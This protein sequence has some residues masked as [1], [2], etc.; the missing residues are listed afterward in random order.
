MHINTKTKLKENK[1]ERKFCVFCGKKPSKKNK[2]HII[3]KWLIE[4]TG[5]KNRQ[6]LVGMDWND[7][8][9][10]DR[11]FSFSS[12]TLPACKLCNS[13]YGEL[14]G[15]TKPILLNIFNNKEISHDDINKLLDWFDKVRI[16]LWFSTIVLN[17]NH[18][19]I[20]PHFY[21]RDRVGKADRA[22]L[23]YKKEGSEQ[24][25]V[26][27]IGAD[28]PLF[29]T[30]PSAFGLRINEYF[31]INIS[32]PFLLHEDFG[33]LK[34]N[35]H[36]I[37]SDS[38][39]NIHAYLDGSH[40]I[41]SPEFLID[42][43]N[44][45][46]S[47]LQAIKVKNQLDPSNDMDIYKTEYSTELFFEG[48]SRVHLAKDGTVSSLPPNG[49]NVNLPVTSSHTFDFAIAM[50]MAMVKYQEKLFLK[51]TDYSNIL[52]N[53]K[54]S[55]ENTTESSLML[56]RAIVSIYKMQIEAYL[57]RALFRA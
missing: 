47:F 28:T 9:L 55:V 3:P 39:Y 54:E 32:S 21:I 7:S 22:L 31:F 46:I 4:L 52:G 17:K 30:M 49:F 41:Q 56:Q 25:G 53:D 12:F 18:N 37:D 51:Y 45:Y 15:E 20:S 10:K 29:H 36:D 57:R 19:G 16:G 23:V 44:N 1:L 26:N 34:L 27:F 11:V 40:N 33:V 38:E 8:S 42:F 35:G 43:P 2:E 13:E 24:K 14:E 48:K 50:A 5:D 6:I